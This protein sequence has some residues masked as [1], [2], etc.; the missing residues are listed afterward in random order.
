MS[1]TVKCEI[2]PNPQ[3]FLLCTLPTVVSLLLSGLRKIHRHSK[4]GLLNCGK[5]NIWGQI[6]LCCV[7]AVRRPVH[8]PWSLPMGDPNSTTHCSSQDNKKELQILPHIIWEAKLLTK[9]NH[10]FKEIKLFVYHRDFKGLNICVALFI[11][12]L[13]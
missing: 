11:I 10:C 13:D 8:Y 1:Y 7:E 4:P 5:I 6:I 12:M 2:L 3:N 9:E